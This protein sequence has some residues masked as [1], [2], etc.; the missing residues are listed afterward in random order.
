MGEFN[1]S[2]KVLTMRTAVCVEWQKKLERGPYVAFFQVFAAD[3]CDLDS[4]SRNAMNEFL[5]LIVFY[6]LKF[7]FIISYCL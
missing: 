1:D 3:V 4:F 2:S 5:F 6:F 7:N